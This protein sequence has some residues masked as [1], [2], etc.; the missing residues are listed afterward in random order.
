MSDMRSLS[1]G[2][3]SFST[4]CFVLSLWAIT[5]APFRALDEFDVYM[6]R[7][8]F[9]ESCKKKKCITVFTKILDGLTVFIFDDNNKKCFLRSKSAY[10]NNI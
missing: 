10:Q 1:G 2:E 8:I 7:C 5:D 3:R 6:V 9:K 4:V